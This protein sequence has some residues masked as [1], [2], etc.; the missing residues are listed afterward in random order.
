[1]IRPAIACLLLIATLCAQAQPKAGVIEYINTYKTLA[2]SEMH[3]TGIPAAIKLAQGIH[4]T[5]AGQSDLVKKSNN[6]FGI[7][8]KATWT[9]DK[10]YH[11]DDARGECFRKYTSPQDSYMDHSNFLKGSTRYAS[12]FELDPTDFEGWAYGL[13]KAGYATNI[14]YSQIL[15]KIINEY[16]LQDY[17]LIALGKMKPE[18]EWLAS[19]NKIM[20]PEQVKMEATT[21]AVEKAMEVEQPV[22][23]PQGEFRINETRVVYVT[24]GTSLLSV[25]E[26][27]GVSLKRILDFNEMKEE[28]IL[29]KG[30]LVYLQRKRKHGQNEFHVVQSNETIYDI[31]QSE[32]IRLESLLSL[33]LLQKGMQPAA[34]EKLYL[35]Y[36]A[37]VRPV[38]ASEVS[39]PIAQ[40]SPAVL[41]TPVDAS[42]TK[43]VVQIKETLFA[44]SKKYGVPVEKLMQWNNLANYDL[45]TG[46]E[47]II[48][49]N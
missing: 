33:N 4:E 3:R 25:A 7:K 31:C 12:L 11:D 5:D 17:T 26:E 34:G 14:K 40:V 29:Q 6:H 49:K 44:I 18:D 48:Y 41:N 23:Y 37:P 16:H 1:M 22:S 39:K 45:K 24:A 9:G 28:N 30:Q 38:L 10:V 21:I 43:H 47:L 27:Y 8:C 20:L 42:Y 36:D 19:I 15:I 46:Q 2:I 35:K 13:K 32:G